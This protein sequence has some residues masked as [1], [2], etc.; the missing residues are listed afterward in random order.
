MFLLLCRPRRKLSTQKD[1][2]ALSKQSNVLNK[3]PCFDV[4]FQRWDALRSLVIH[5]KGLRLESILHDINGSGGE[6]P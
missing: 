6:K 1:C 2:L 3:A 4:E 5:A